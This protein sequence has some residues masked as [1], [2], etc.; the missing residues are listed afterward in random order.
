M[1]VY[2]MGYWC[3]GVWVPF[4]MCVQF[5]TERNCIAFSSHTSTSTST[6]TT[7]KKKCRAEEFQ[8]NQ[9]APND[10]VVCR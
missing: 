4:D 1:F 8:K 3:D 5:H 9:L 7:P 6:R 2:Y 10:C